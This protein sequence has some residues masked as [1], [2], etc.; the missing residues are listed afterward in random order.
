MSRALTLLRRSGIALLCLSGAAMAQQ[1]PDLDALL[2]AD[3]MLA[4]VEQASNV[5]W[6]AEAAGG[7]AT[8]RS[9]GSTT[10]NQRLSFALQ[11]D[12]NFAPGWRAVLSDRL[13]V[14]WPSL[15]A[16]QPAINTIKEAYVSWQAQSDRL[17]DV[18]RINVR[19]GVALGYNPN[20]YFKTASL[21]SVVS[22]D[23]A[24]LKENRQGSVMLRAQKLWSGGSSSLVFSP[25]LSRSPNAAQ[26]NPD[27][28]ATNA[29]NRWLLSV[30]QTITEGWQPQLLLYKNAGQAVQLGLNLTS[31]V[32][33]ATVLFVEWSGGQARSSMA[34][35]L[36]AQGRNVAD[37]TRWRNR[38]A[39]GATYTT[40]NKISLTA[41]FDY[42]GA[43]LDD[44]QWNAAA[45]APLGVYAAYRG[46]LQTVQEAPTK[47][48]VFVYA[49]WQDA[50]INHLDISAMQRYD[51]A[52][53]S[54]LQ[55][56]EARYHLKQVE[57]A[58]QWQRN[59]GRALS[60]YG[61][62]LQSQNWAVLARYYF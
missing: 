10:S 30:S 3:Q 5:R 59:S 11:Y 43:A 55:W 27:V 24:S 56:L 48:A 40:T 38:L 13:D 12:G 28:G 46:Y 2:L 60:N 17:F 6:F 26:F 39:S 19:N 57:F 49:S 33:D 54:R 29:E 50:L 20:D 7:A 32:D 22:S 14:N 31:L 47:R 18:G 16:Q 51:M 15:I 25:G 45:H 62:A 61:A 9:D 52:D 36:L 42:N 53:A 34:Q 44:A 35:A 8:R 4:P 21:R 23:P 1:D 41:E 58:L 37:D